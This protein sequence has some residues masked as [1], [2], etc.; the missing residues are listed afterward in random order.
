MAALKQETGDTVRFSGVGG[1]RMLERGL[2]SL[3]PMSD[4]SI[5]GLAEVVPH[6]PRLFCRLI[7]TVSEIERINP[8]VVVTIDSPDFCFR[9]AQR[10]R[11]KGITL[12]HYV[13][14]TVWA[15]K[16]SRARK[17]AAF[18]DHLLALLPIEPQIFEAAGLA[19][20][21]V[22]HPA[23][24]SGADCGDGPGFRQRYCIAAEVPLI[25]VLPGSRH[26]ETSLL[27]PIFERT[28]VMLNEARPGLRVVVP[29]VGTVANEVSAAI[30][31]WTV[32]AFTVQGERE[33][34]DA[35][36]ASDAA[37]AA[38][39]T[40]SLELAMARV[41]TVI[42]YRMSALT[43][44][45]ARRV[46][47]IRFASLIN[48]ILD[49]EIIPERL[50]EACC[51][52]ELSIAVENLLGNEAVAGEQSDAAR[53]ALVLLGYGGP[54]PSQRAAQTILEVVHSSRGQA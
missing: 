13:A 25:C 48:I 52:D 31:G 20:T 32:P 17:I 16:P 49:Q 26:G 22:G 30:A 2:T 10:L 54:A 33:K 21:C 38:S 5:M 1:E 3:F 45:I 4:L 43:A 53:E 9:V 18:L 7:R 28:V 42:A 41:P 44:W 39:G 12:I 40:V 35:F 23:V 29:T 6:L 15:W 46:V 24:E 50:Q 34:Y 11:G 14:P 47:R 51:P 36:A 27:L 37:L 8:D 19:T